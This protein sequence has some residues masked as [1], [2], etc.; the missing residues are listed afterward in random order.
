M[1]M[2]MNKYTQFIKM[3]TKIDERSNA[4]PTKR[5]HTYDELGVEHNPVLYS[6]YKKEDVESKFLLV[7]EDLSESRLFRFTM[8][9]KINW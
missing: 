1:D 6:I 9:F 4:K 7:D 2:M 5:G 3:F 8:S